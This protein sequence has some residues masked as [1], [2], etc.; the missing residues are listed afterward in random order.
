MESAYVCCAWVHVVQGISGSKVTDA[1]ELSVLPAQHPRSHSYLFSPEPC[2]F[3]HSQHS[4][5]KDHRAQWFLTW[6]SCCHLCWQC[7]FIASMFL[8]AGT[9]H[10]GWWVAQQKIVKKSHAMLHTERT[11]RYPGAT[12]SLHY[13]D[14]RTVHICNIQWEP[15]ILDQEIWVKRHFGKNSVL[16]RVT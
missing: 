1:A 14:S 11:N 12:D 15:C 5:G 2:F 13:T 3:R 4:K 6:D 7:Q 16:K 8:H 10:S 9:V